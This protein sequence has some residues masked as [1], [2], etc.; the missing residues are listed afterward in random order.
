MFFFNGKKPKPEKFGSS[1]K[2]L[3]KTIENS[4][5]PA[6]N[7]NFHITLLAPSIFISTEPSEM[8]TKLC[9]IFHP[10]FSLQYLPNSRQ[11][12]RQ[13]SSSF[14]KKQ[15]KNYKFADILPED[16]EQKYVRGWGPG[17][18]C[19]NAAGN[20]VVM[21]HKPT[22]CVVKVGHISAEEILGIF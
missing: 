13:K 7:L 22:N 15:L 10:H 16:C 21:R 14:A 19:V 8:A 12:I 2:N 3:K 18:S 17:G 4:I 1:M 5:S 6:N 11:F 9:R 20:A